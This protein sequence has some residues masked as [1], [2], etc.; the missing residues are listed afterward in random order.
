MEFFK[1]QNAAFQKLHAQ[2]KDFVKFLTT[3]ERQFKNIS[4]GE[5]PV[6]EETLPSLLNGLKLIWTISRHINQTENK[7]ED[8]LESISNE[9]CDKVR[10]QI[11][12]K[13]IFRLKPEVAINIIN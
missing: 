10:S 13:R 12:I 2:A 4:R 11:D 1:G 6:I 3:L 5:L 7:M 9:I 8:L